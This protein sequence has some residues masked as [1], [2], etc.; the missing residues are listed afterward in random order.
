MSPTS[1]QIGRLERIIAQGREAL[2][3]LRDDLDNL[4]NAGIL[5]RDRVKVLEAQLPLPRTRAEMEAE[6]DAITNLATAKDYLKTHLP[7]EQ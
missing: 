6:I 1:R 2:N 5:V 3:E 7:R 4:R